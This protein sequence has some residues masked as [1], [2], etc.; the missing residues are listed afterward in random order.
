MQAGK[1]CIIA[2]TNRT[3]SP[4]ASDIPTAQEAGYSD[5]AVDG[6]QGFF[7]WRDMPDALRDRIAADVRA[8]AADP[9][10]AERLKTIGQAVRVGTTQE[11][12]A[13]IA[14][15]RAKIARIAR[16]IG[17]RPQP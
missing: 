6:F 14:E 2:V 11:F 15:Q 17:L 12:V 9:A 1:A 5:L 13:M 16:A 7:G 8:V 4:A 10:L 3:R